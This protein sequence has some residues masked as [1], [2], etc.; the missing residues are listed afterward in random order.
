MIRAIRRAIFLLLFTSHDEAGDKH[1][2]TRRVL[3]F[4]TRCIMVVP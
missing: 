2:D 4:Q 3:V 1:L